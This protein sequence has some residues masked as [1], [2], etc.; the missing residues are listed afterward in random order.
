MPSNLNPFADALSAAVGPPPDPSQSPSLNP[1]AALFAASFGPPLNPAANR[2]P[3]IVNTDSNAPTPPVRI[4]D[5][6]TGEITQPQIQAL[7][8]KASAIQE[9]IRKYEPAGLDVTNL[10][11]QPQ[12]DDPNLEPL[13]AQNQ[14]RFTGATDNEK[15]LANFLGFLVPGLG[16][17]QLAGLASHIAGRATHDLKGAAIE[18]LESLGPAALL[19]IAPG[20]I[21]AVRGVGDSA[22]NAFSKS[23]GPAAEGIHGGADPY[24]EAV[25]PGKPDT[26]QTQSAPQ[27]QLLDASQNRTYNESNATK[28]GRRSAS[29]PGTPNRFDL[30]KIW[31]SSG[32]RGFD[33][34]GDGESP[35]S[36]PRESGRNNRSVL[37]RNASI[38]QIFTPTNEFSNHLQLGGMSS[39]PVGGGWY[40]RWVP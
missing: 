35:G 9:S 17:V 27:A 6:T 40:R 11:S 4:K 34:S 37:L 24:A 12:G 39:V 1:F 18:A 22:S 38:R 16:E 36:D 31:N 23:I 2:L 3:S 32:R 14:T 26:L 19:H 29:A 7:Y 25:I 10:H 5:A 20:A 28:E 15:Q 30:L 21:S 33:S 8:Q 13:L